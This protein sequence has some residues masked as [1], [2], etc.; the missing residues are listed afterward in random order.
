MIK[1]S[2]G[3]PHAVFVGVVILVIFSLLA[4]TQIPVQLKPEIEPLQYSISTI[5]PGAGALEV[6]DQITNKLE[7]ELASLNDLSE[8]TSSSSEGIS[9]IFLLFADNADQS[10]ALLDI[11]QSIER[12]PGLPEGA[13]KPTITKG[14][15][16]GQNAIMWIATA[17]SASL[18]EK[19]DLIDQIV[20]PA[21]LRVNGVGGVLVFGGDERRIIVVPDL[22]KLSAYQM[23]IT[24]LGTALGLEN[25]DA[26]GGQLDEGDRQF[27]VRTTG[28]FRNMD[29]VRNTVVR[30]GPTG[31]ITVGDVARVEDSRNRKESYVKNN[32]EPAVAFGVL[33]QSGAN[34]VT[35][36]KGVKAKL[37]EFNRQFEKSGIGL[38]F[39]EA[40]SELGYV[41]EG[42]ELVQH[43][44]LIGAVLAAIVLALFLRAGRPILITVIS[45][46]ISLVSVFLVLQAMDRT[47]N[48]IAL[49]G[50]SFAVGLVVDDAI[51]ALENIERHMNELGKPV[52]QAAL[53]GVDEV[54]GAILSSTLVRVAVFIPIVLNTTEAGLLFKDIAIAIVTSIMVSL[55]VTLTVVPSF[56]ALLLRSGSSRKR[57]AETNPALDR[58]LRVVEFQWLGDVIQAAYTR[59]VTWATVGRGPSHNMGRIALLAAVGILFLSSLTLLPSAS[60]LPNGTQGF[61][62]VAAQPHVGQ[63]PE[64]TSNAYVPLE[65]AALAD[66]R[67]ER[68]FSVASPFFNGVGVKVKQEEATP[69]NFVELIG[70][71]SQVGFGLP[72]F[73]FVFPIQF[74]IFQTQDK[75]FT[76]EVTG[77]DLT[78]LNQIAGQLQGTL[79]ARQ[80]DIVA[81]LGYGAVQS[82]YDEGVPELNVRLNP[83]K[84]RELGLF[85]SDVALVVESM[86]AG[87]QVST[88]SDAGREFDLE[89]Q[90]DPQVVKNRDALAN[91]LIQTRDGRSVRLEEIA[92]I[93]EATGPTAI[94]HFNRER[95]IQLTVATRPD[96]PTQ[97]ALDRTEREIIDPQLKSLPAGYGV[98]FGAAADKL[99]DTYRSLIFQGILAVVIIYLLLVA[100]FRSFYYPFIVL[101]TIPLAWSGSFLAISIAY[102]VTR[103][104][105]QFDVLGMLGLII[106]SGIVAANAIL[107]IAQMIN[108]EKEGLSPNEALRESASTRLRPI[109]MTV[110]AAVFG[111]LPLAL[112][113]GSGSELYRSLG[114]VVVG[115][116]ISSTIFTLLVVPTMMS[117]INDL[118]SAWAARRGRGQS[119]A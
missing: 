54:W 28:K 109:M 3:N 97:T 99:R 1:A 51:V 82:S 60:Y 95:S 59:F 17:G 116:L 92:T 11:I 77:P 68:I 39:E 66:P 64:V 43:D 16:Q 19:Y 71:L 10:K 33:R 117:L 49:A 70:S 47:I 56:A 31:S 50:I 87:R 32:G 83:Q 35:T 7:R 61:I 25:R 118:Q 90:G 15:N 96:I 69:Q 13:E 27:N 75:Q 63:R 79:L 22:E 55:L 76:L 119:G 103:S 62:F 18:N 37:E 107:I 81:P 8:I 91:L 73:K 52:R 45:I 36:I 46:P 100:L 34:T 102:K 84:A 93:T 65:Q 88:F 44:L 104:V 41:E 12:V 85:V 9:N 111:M 113:Q 101:I 38:Q 110:L 74:S 58:V 112:G 72:G 115:G 89:I 6:E 94:R 40:Y 42:I 80:G 23:S 20:Q 105:V 53:D 29:D 14:A 108:F 4:Y 30:Y 86:I 98:R 106:L 21:L 26:R 24:E 114:I 67:V 2:I 57:L 78:T 5:Y 48:I